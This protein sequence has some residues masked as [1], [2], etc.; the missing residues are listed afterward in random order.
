MLAVLAVETSAISYVT[1]LPVGTPEDELS[2]S[3]KGPRTTVPGLDSTSIAL[4]LMT[5]EDREDTTEDA[6]LQRPTAR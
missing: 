5:L 6:H 1:A 4:Q 3:E 2:S